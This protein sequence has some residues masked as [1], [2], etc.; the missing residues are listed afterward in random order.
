MEV[1]TRNWWTGK[2]VLVSLASRAA[3][4]IHAE[5]ERI[6]R[7]FGR[8]LRVRNEAAELL[9]MVLARNSTTDAQIKNSPVRSSESFQLGANRAIR[10]RT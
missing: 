6:S 3:V 10:I 2:K 7:N 5:L 1:A 4:A 8:S 9:I